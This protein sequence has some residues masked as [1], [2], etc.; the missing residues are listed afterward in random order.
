MSL[1]STTTK[2]P[3]RK[4]FSTTGLDVVRKDIQEVFIDERSK[5]FF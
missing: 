4:R 2:M 1:I 3:G 5:S